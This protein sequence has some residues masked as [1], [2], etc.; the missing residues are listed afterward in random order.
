MIPAGVVF[1]LYGTLVEFGA[2]RAAAARI[3][4]DPDAFVSAWRAKL[5]GYTFSAA[6]TGH[7]EDFGQI[8]RHAL[9]YTAAASGLSIVREDLDALIG[10]W[11][12][13]DAYPDALPALRKLREAG[14]KTAVLTNASMRQA[15]DALA[16]AKLAELF[17]A[18]L[19]SDEIGTF[20]PDPAAYR[21]ASRHFSVPPDRLVLVTAAGWEAMGGRQYGL[22]VVW[23]NRDGAPPEPFGPPPSATITTLAELAAAI[24]G[25]SVAE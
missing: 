5:V 25:I 2:V 9:H 19:S 12:M 20:K 24:E 3:S 22:N 15:R 21:I 23:C 14:L 16:Y 18:V 13:T 11:R 1:D 8:V 4:P 17:D 10:A 7:Y 6:V